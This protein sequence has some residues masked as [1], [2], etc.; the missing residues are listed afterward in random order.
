[1]SHEIEKY[2]Q[3]ACEYTI[4]IK[5][6]IPIFLEP[7]VFMKSGVPCTAQKIQ[8]HLEPEIHLTPE[9]KSAPAVCAPQNGHN[10]HNGHNAYQRELVPEG[11]EQA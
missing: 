8:V 7:R 2:Y 3:D 1:M 6:N 5:L 9:V 10:G 4:A 11:Y